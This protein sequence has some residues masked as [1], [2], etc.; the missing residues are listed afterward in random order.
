MVRRLLTNEHILGIVQAL[1]IL[2]IVALA[3][4]SGWRIP[5]Y[6]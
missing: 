3:F 1:L 4:A 5:N 2:G 6:G